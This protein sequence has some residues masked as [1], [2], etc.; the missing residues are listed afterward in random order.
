[1]IIVP[2]DRKFDILTGGGGRGTGGGWGRGGGVTVEWGSQPCVTRCTMGNCVSW[3]I[4]TGGSA[5]G[6]M[7][8]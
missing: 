7:L 5:H 4:S 6:Q 2:S 3:E 8:L 1:M